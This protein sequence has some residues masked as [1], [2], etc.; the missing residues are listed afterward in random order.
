M[1]HNLIPGKKSGRSQPEH[2]TLY[3]RLLTEP[4]AVKDRENNVCLEGYI[5]YF[6]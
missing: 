6:T 3:V 5:Y 1:R 4:V 2:F